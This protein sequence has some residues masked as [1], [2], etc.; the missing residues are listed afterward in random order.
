M[1]EVQLRAL[2]AS[3]SVDEEENVTAKKNS[4]RTFIIGPYFYSFVIHDVAN[5]CSQTF[6]EGKMSLL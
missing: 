5:T 1:A 3:A 6:Q 4:W 2:V